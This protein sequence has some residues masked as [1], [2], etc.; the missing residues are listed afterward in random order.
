MT[1]PSTASLDQ[2]VAQYLGLEELSATEELLDISGAKID[3]NA[4]P[5]LKRRLHEEEAQ[6]ATLGTRGYVRM[7]EKREQLIM[8]LKQ[9][10]VALEG[11][12]HDTSNHSLETQY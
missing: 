3:M 8:C 10:I 2:L 11:T 9:L 7:R 6:A 1:Q 12:D 4:L 5:L